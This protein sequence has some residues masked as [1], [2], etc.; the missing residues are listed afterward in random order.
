MTNKYFK[1]LA[2]F[3]S[4]IAK[5]VSVL[6]NF[7]RDNQKKFNRTPNSLSPDFSQSYF[8]ELVTLIITLPY[9]TEDLFKSQLLSLGC[10]V[11]QNCR[12]YDFNL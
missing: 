10:K 2:E 5:K 3:N 1:D 6:E 8:S 4:K 11:N 7:L 9:I 12:E